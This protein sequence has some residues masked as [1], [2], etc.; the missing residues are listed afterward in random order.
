[1]RHGC[2]RVSANI[3]L[4]V[5]EL[6]VVIAILEQHQWWAVWESRTAGAFNDLRLGSCRRRRFAVASVTVIKYTCRRFDITCQLQR[7]TGNLH[8]EPELGEFCKFLTISEKFPCWGSCG[9]Q[10]RVH[11]ITVQLV[12]QSSLCFY[13]R[14]Y[15]WVKF[16]ECYDCVCFAK[17]V[18]VV[19][20][21]VFLRRFT[22]LLRK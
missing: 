8:G 14:F 19:F 6:I 17:N 21:L 1:M 2:C 22:V 16:R 12:R 13:N 7:Y 18:W 3:S 9:W 4:S 15:I 10:F 11:H 20:H 5:I